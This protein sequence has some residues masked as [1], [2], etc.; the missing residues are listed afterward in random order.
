VH[1]ERLASCYESC[2]DLARRMKLRTVAFCA[3]STGVF[4]YPSGPA[5][6]TAVATVKAWLGRNPDAIDLVVFDV[7]TNADEAAYRPLLGPG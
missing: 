7:F 2:L 3:I 6:E 5:A 4:G 1:R